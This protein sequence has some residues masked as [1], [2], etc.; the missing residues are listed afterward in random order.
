[1]LDAILQPE[2]Y[3]ELYGNYFH[4]V[5]IE[6]YPPRGDAKEGWDNIDIVGW[7]GQP[8]QIKMN[9]LCRDSI[10]AA[11]VA[12]DLILFLDLAQRAGLAGIQEWLSFYFK[13]PMSRP[14]LK[15]EHDLFIQHLKLTNTLRI[16][17]GEEVLDHS[18]LDYYEGDLSNP[19][20]DEAPIRRSGTE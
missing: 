18:G 11:P 5:R 16:L 14:D 6:Y 8:M 3:K 7:L 1:M 2:M 9:F 13:S 10:L 12:L 17:V 15:P 4:K 19:A 20:A